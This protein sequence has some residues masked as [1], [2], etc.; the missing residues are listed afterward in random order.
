[1]IGRVIFFAVVGLWLAN[2]SAALA[3]P[4][5][6]VVDAVQVRATKA[7]FDGAILIGEADGTYAIATTGKAR[8]DY[9][10]I[11][12]RLGDAGSGSWPSRSRSARFALLAGMEGQERINNQN[13]PP[14]FAQ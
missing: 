7:G 1:M 4:P 12:C 2:G 13:S 8:V 10:A 14:A 5:M 6:P 3:K 11:D 9:K